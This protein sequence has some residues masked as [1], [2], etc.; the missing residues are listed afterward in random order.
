MK[1][2][3]H[4]NGLA[5]FGKYIYDIY[6]SSNGSDSYIAYG[7]ERERNDPPGWGPIIWHTID[8]ASGDFDDFHGIGIT[9]RSEFSATET[10]PC[11][12]YANGNNVS[13]TWL[14]KDGAPQGRRGDIDVSDGSTLI[15]SGRA[16]FDM[17]RVPKQLRVIDGWAEDFGSVSGGF[18]LKVGIDGSGLGVVG[19]AI[20]SDGYFE[21]F[22][23]QDTSDT[24]RSM[25]V[26]CTWAGVSSLTDTNGPRLR[27]VMIRAVAL[28]DTTRVWTFLCA[29]RDGEARTGKKIRSEIEGYKN[30][31]KKYELPDGDSF[32]GVLTRIRLLRADEVRDLTPYNQQ[33]PHYVM[34]VTVREMVS[35]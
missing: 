2:Q 3:G 23:T 8:M 25:L 4:W 9:E 31:L 30:D 5:A 11:L 6:V 26:G 15:V 21:R 33:P 16:D 18:T 27:D 24:G 19:A 7:R 28:P 10:R 34:E 29:A 32:S 1:A 13:Y 20:Q 17:P 35:S 14:D 22:W 12:W